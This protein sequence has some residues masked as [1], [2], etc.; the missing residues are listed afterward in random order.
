[1][2]IIVRIL[3]ILERIVSKMYAFLWRQRIKLSC[4][5]IKKKG[6]R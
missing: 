5:L 2:K 6:K 4:N 3:Y 1:M